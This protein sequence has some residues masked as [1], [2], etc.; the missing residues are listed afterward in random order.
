MQFVFQ[1][2]YRK[3]EKEVKRATSQNILEL[4]FWARVYLTPPAPALCQELLW[5]ES[6]HQLLLDKGEGDIQELLKPI[7][8][9]ACY[10]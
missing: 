3:S 8:Q 10:P 4:G 7:P 5:E 6:L 2:V 1:S 9:P